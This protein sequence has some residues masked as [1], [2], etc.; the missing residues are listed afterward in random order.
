M[1]FLP[2]QLPV[3]NGSPLTR[4]ILSQ[5]LV[6]VFLFCCLLLPSQ[7][8]AR[9]AKV[10]LAD[11]FD[12]PVGKPNSAGY[13]KARGLRLRSPTH[14]G[15]DWNGRAGGNTDLRDPVYSCADGIVTFAH[16]VRKGW[17]NVVLVRHAYR[18]PSSGK[19]KYVDSLYGHLDKMMVK[20]GQNLKRGQQ[21]GTIGSNFGM[22]AAHLHFEIRHNINTGMHRSSVPSDLANWAD[23]TKFIKKY[24]RLNRE[25]RPVAIPTGTY[26]EYAGFKGL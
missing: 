22:Y 6:S 1:V 5:G 8:D 26:K 18:D 14:F 24:R 3:G 25:W 12:F 9:G 23:P 15:E 21:L 20:V 10:N 13:Y 2:K 4:R 11:G 19:I 7:L 17:G 16:N